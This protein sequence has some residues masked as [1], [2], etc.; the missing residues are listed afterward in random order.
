MALKK[1]FAEKL[2]NIITQGTAPFG[3]RQQFAHVHGGPAYYP[4]YEE[5]RSKSKR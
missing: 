3:E 4:D 5:H 2:Q 1:V